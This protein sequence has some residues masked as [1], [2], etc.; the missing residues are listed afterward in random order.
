MNKKILINESNLLKLI[1]HEVKQQIIKENMIANLQDKILNYFL[2]SFSKKLNREEIEL[3]GQNI[4]GIFGSNV[5]FNQVFDRLKKQRPITEDIDIELSKE[6]VSDLVVKSINKLAGINIKALGG[7]FVPV[8][9]RILTSNTSMV[10]GNDLKVWVITLLSS[11]AIVALSKIYQ[12]L[13]AE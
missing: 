13:R 11:L 6:G 5:N 7:I 2:S 8:I 10:N 4:E 3:A 9:G 12:K 1:N